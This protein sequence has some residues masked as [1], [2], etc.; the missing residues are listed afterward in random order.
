MV[1]SYVL[2]LRFRQVAMDF[3]QHKSSLVMRLR[4]ESLRE[5]YTSE[6]K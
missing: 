6:R 5:I 2:R 1:R 4:N 3:K